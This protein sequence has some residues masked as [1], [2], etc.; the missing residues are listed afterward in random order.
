MKKIL[1][2]SVFICFI[3]VINI[4]VSANELPEL[5]L[6]P[7]NPSF[8]IG[9][10]PVTN[11]QYKTFIDNTKTKA[12][13]YWKNG[14]YPKDKGNHP[15]VFV[16]YNEALKYCQW[17]EHKHPQ[18]SFR[19]PT[20]S[21]WEYAANGGKNYI[22]PWGSQLKENY[23][24]Y[25]KNIALFYLQQNPIVTYINPKSTKYGQSMPLNQVIFINQNGTVSGWIDHKNYTG[26]V[27]TDLYKK[28]MDNGGYTTPVN[29]YPK[30]KSFFGVYDMSGNVWEWTS[31]KTTATNGAEKGQYVYAIKGGSWYSNSNSCKTTM[32]GEGRRANIGFNTVGFRVA[33]EKK[34]I[35]N[36]TN[37]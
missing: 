21:E 4:Q 30:G 27:Y 19:L 23:F 2:F 26:F 17:L 9:K 20:I 1:W 13:I 6:I 33:A 36:S 16:S 10:F 12:P 5:V 22:Y 29:K 18:Y 35:K 28:I 32:K 7:D 24:N 11:S 8:Y 3:S 14:T 37:K 25:N 31:S 34:H 15:V